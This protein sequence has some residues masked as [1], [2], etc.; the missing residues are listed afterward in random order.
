MV[1]FS[2]DKTTQQTGSYIAFVAICCYL[3]FFSTSLSPVPWT[4]QS[5]I[6]PLHLRG[7]GNSAS[8][9]SN[10]FCNFIIAQAF[11]S[12]TKTALGTVLTFAFLAFV[13][14][15]GWFF[16]YYIVPETKDKG[17][18]EILNDILKKGPQ[19]KKGKHQ[20]LAEIAETESQD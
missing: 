10:W 3:V 18:D 7:A 5:E 17:F 20:V 16:V 8:T 13:T 15:G 11:L 12:L 6:F 19:S 2:K 4:I 14:V 9:F 1:D